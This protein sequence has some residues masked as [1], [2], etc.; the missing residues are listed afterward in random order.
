MQDVIT[1]SQ[2]KLEK[3][4]EV[5]SD[6]QELTALEKRIDDKKKKNL[7]LKKANSELQ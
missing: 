2:K 1:N 3:L 4:Q 6:H 5:V 7:Y